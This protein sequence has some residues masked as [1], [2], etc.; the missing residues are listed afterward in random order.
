MISALVIIVIADGINPACTAGVFTICA[1][2][3]VPGPLDGMRLSGELVLSGSD[4]L[5]FYEHSDGSRTM[6]LAK[7]GNDLLLTAN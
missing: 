2:E 4:G 5:R 7:R 6:K 1:D 3:F